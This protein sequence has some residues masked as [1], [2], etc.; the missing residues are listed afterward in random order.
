[1]HP[2]PTV[3]SLPACQAGAVFEPALHL[4]KPGHRIPRQLLLTAAALLGLAGCASVPAP[5]AQ[6]ALAN[7]AVNSAV[8][9]GGVEMA[10]TETALAR[11]KLRRAQ[12]AM[13]TEDHAGALRLSQ[14]AQ[15]DAQ[16]A[17]AKAQAEKAR[18]SAQALQEAGRVLREEMARQP[19]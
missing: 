10:P 11:E 9:A 6:M 14:Q 13:A 18:R 15:A 5:T 1:M 8:A 19:R 16:L 17:E 4:R 2:E 3:T 12:A 7:A